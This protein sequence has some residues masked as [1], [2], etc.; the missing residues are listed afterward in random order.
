LDFTVLLIKVRD[1]AD[2]AHIY[3]SPSEGAEAMSWFSRRVR[4][5]RMHSDDASGFSLVE[6]IV[7]LALILLVMTSS[8]VFFVRS[9]QTSSGQQSRQAAISLSD[10][11]IELARAVPVASL[12]NGRIQSTSDTQ[13]TNLP[14]AASAAKAASLEMWD[15]PPV[16]PTIAVPFSVQDATTLVNKTQYIVDTAIGGCWVTSTA[17]VRCTAPATPPTPTP[18]V[19]RIIVDVHWTAKQGQS[20]GVA[21]RCDY[22]VT[23]L[24]DASP[25]PLFNVNGP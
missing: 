16:A 13:W 6:V 10:Q 22:V 20:C 17:P 3:E 15:T 2:D 21:S 14:A 9:L 4:A 19:Y 25:D 18:N 5:A 7:A 11:A 23:T 12:L 24:R 1:H 8:V